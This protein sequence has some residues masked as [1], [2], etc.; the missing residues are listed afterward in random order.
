MN[1]NFSRKILLL[2]I[3]IFGGLLLCSSASATT[4]P[5]DPPVPSELDSIEFYDDESAYYPSMA[6]EPGTE[7]FCAAYSTYCSVDEKYHLAYSCLF[8]LF[9]D[10]FYHQVC[11]D[12]PASTDYPSDIAFRPS[13]AFDP[14][15]GNAGI[16]FYRT[17]GATTYVNYVYF[18]NLGWHQEQVDSWSSGSDTRVSLAFKSDG[19]P[20]VAYINA[21]YEPAR[22][23]YACRIGEDD[24]SHSNVAPAAKNNHQLSLVF[25]EDDYPHIG[26]Y[27]MSV[28]MPAGKEDF[29]GAA[30]LLPPVAAPGIQEAYNTGGPWLSN[31]IFPMG[32][33]DDADYI[34]LAWRNNPEN[35]RMLCAAFDVTDYLGGAGKED[36]DNAAYFATANKSL[37][38][39][40][41]STGI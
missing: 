37:K 23:Y 39:A 30:Y 8:E 35:G 26:Y 34:D 16:A 3:L 18:D 36:F 11:G 19:T 29:D 28:A 1:N 22:V 27:G 20:C 31:R 2:L 12:G 25:D 17:R 33:E 14:V 6:V 15:D 38:F 24:W 41:K 5:P 9:P 10:R 13:L 4:D 32:V 21:G 40:C 7:N